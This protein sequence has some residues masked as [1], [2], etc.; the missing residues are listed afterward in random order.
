METSNW[1]LTVIP[2]YGR[3]YDTAEEAFADWMNDKDFY[4]CTPGHPSYINKSD[5]EKYGV[6]NNTVR[7]RFNNK[8]EIL[9]AK[10]D[11]ANNKWIKIAEELDDI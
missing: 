6:V 3:D 4:I 7:I 2:A 8:T 9:L 5:A 10:Y 11:K 1:E